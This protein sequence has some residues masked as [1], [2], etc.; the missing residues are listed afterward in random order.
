[1][2][3]DASLLLISHIP[4]QFHCG[5]AAVVRRLRLLVSPICWNKV[6][7]FLGAVAAINPPGNEVEKAN[8]GKIEIKEKFSGQPHGRGW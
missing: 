8:L 5:R 4:K 3:L 6:G 1:M 7:R 2:G